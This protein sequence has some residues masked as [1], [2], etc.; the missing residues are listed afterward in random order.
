MSEY[1]REDLGSMMHIHCHSENA[2]V[3]LMFL[4]SKEQL[5]KDKMLEV[6][7][8]KIQDITLRDEVGIHAYYCVGPGPG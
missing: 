7:E 8:I 2:A 5:K 1:Y 4:I 3:G 6:L